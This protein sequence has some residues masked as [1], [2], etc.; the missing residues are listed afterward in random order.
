MDLFEFS[1]LSLPAIDNKLAPPLARRL[2]ASIG[3][4][5]LSQRYETF[6]DEGK[7]T[8]PPWAPLSRR[9]AQA[10]LKKY[11]GKSSKILGG[12][13][14]L[15]QSFSSRSARASKPD[16]DGSLSVTETEATLESHVPYA[17]IHNEGGTILKKNTRQEM[18]F[19]VYTKG[20]RAGQ[21]AF[22]SKKDV[23]KGD[24]KSHSIVRRRVSSHSMGTYITIPARP[25]DQFSERDTDEIRKLIEDALK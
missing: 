9:Y 13:G 10:K 19:K 17:K 7:N 12:R 24:G 8:S 6:N 5:M 4:L 18:D 23:E 22:A 2:M 11:R 25:F 21:H 16:G 3:A 1:T 14:D 20:K 15:R